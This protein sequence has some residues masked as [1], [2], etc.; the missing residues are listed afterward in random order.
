MFVYINQLKYVF[1]K[2]MTHALSQHFLDCYMLRQ[3]H[4]LNIYKVVSGMERTYG[5]IAG[6][7]W[8]TGSEIYPK[9]RY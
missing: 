1:N 8:G 9:C 7:I 5:L 2:I 3:V 4:A 6:G